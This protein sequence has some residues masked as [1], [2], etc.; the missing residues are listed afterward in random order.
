MQFVYNIS[1]LFYIA[2]KLMHSHFITSY[3]IN[4][5]KRSLLNKINHFLSSRTFESRLISVDVTNIM[6]V[7]CEI[8]YL[9]RTLI[10]C[11][12][13][14]CAWYAVVSPTAQKIKLWQIMIIRMALS[15]VEFPDDDRIAPGRQLIEVLQS[16]PGGPGAWDFRSIGLK[17]KNAVVQ[18]L[19]YLMQYLSYRTE[20]TTAKGHSNILDA[21]SA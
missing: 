19:S 21:L 14:Y 2:E 5:T 16:T 1:F 11:L 3:P 10:L 13:P 6:L 17:D 4:V 15:A 8:S 18:K 12:S 9:L 20:K 7:I